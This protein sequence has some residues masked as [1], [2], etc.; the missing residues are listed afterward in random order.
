MSLLKN[1]DIWKGIIPRVCNFDLEDYCLIGLVGNNTTGMNGVQPD[2]SFFP[3]GL[4]TSA[5]ATADAYIKAVNEFILATMSHYTDGEDDDGNPYPTCVTE[6]EWNAMWNLING[7]DGPNIKF[8][9]MDIKRSLFF[10]SLMPNS[11]KRTDVD[12]TRRII[13]YV[14]PYEGPN[15][16]VLIPYSI[17]YS[18]LLY[19]TQQAYLECTK[20]VRDLNQSVKRIMKALNNDSFPLN[21][22]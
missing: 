13:Y 2:N 16:N 22:P 1:I 20:A 6:A 7:P 4:F 8:K 10:N 3:D 18:T 15:D 11:F 14:R 12:N 21:Q 17:D 5:R 19:P 9:E